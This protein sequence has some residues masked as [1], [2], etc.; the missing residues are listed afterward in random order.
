MILIFPKKLIEEN[1][2]IVIL[3]PEPGSVQ[4]HP[5]MRINPL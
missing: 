1:K 2:K 3:L 5:F 4:S